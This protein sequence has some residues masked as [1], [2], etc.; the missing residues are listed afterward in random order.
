MRVTIALTGLAG[1]AALA[2]TAQAQS[3]I[4]YG[5][6]KLLLTGGVSQVEGSAGGGLTPWAVIGGYGAANQTGGNA[7]YTK[8]DTQDYTVKSYG[9]LVGIHDRVEISYARQDFDTQKVGAALGLGYG[10]TLSQDTVGVKIRLLGSAVLDQ[11]RWW[12]QVSAGVQFKSNN[13][14]SLVKALGARSGKGTDWYVSATKLYLAHSLLLNATIRETKANQYGILGFGGKD[15]KYHTEFEGSAAWLLSRKLAIGVE[16]RTKPDNLAVAKEGSAMD[17]FVAYAP[18][19]NIS[20]TLAYA[21]L[22]NIV[23]RRQSG[24]YA[25]LQVGF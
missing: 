10:Y 19:K 2:G 8:V 18:T 1:L 24:L 11:D 17:A 12:P 9:A 3:V 14:T 22:G 21:D 5:G 13:R 20:V 6:G 15:N 23:T 4:P 16:V 7:F 25:S